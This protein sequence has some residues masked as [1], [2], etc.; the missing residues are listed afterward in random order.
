[1]GVDKLYDG[2][3]GGEVT[4]GVG[5][6]VDKLY[7]GKG[8][9]EV[10][11]GVGMGVGKLYDGKGGGEVTVGVWM[12]VGKLYDGKGGGEVMVDPTP[13]PTVTSP[14]PCNYTDSR[15]QPTTQRPQQ[16]TFF[17]DPLPL[18]DNLQNYEYDIRRIQQ[19][20]L[21]EPDTLFYNNIVTS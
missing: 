21:T 14:P 2:K 10:T 9:G 5:M 20:K 18:P 16:M 7:D 8:G 6:G 4:V 15:L 11:V 1:M 17:P 3:G 19:D 13:T 12:G